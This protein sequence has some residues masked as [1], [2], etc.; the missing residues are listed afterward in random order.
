MLDYFRYLVFK[1][2]FYFKGIRFFRTDIIPSKAVF[3]KT[4]FKTVDD[5]QLEFLFYRE[6]FEDI[7]FKRGKIYKENFHCYIVQSN[8]DES[9][10]NIINQFNNLKF[11]FNA[12]SL[13]FTDEEKICHALLDVYL[14]FIKHELLLQTKK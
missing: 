4:E 13:A 1:L 3:R 12:K 9:Y 7:V 11:V 10:S 14:S 6:I 5:K 2:I 8:F